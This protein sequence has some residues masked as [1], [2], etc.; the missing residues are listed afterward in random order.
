MPL[1][2]HVTDELEIPDSAFNADDIATLLI[3]GGRYGGAWIMNAGAMVDGKPD[4]DVIG[5][6]ETVE[7]IQGP[8]PDVAVDSA[9]VWVNDA[10]VRQGWKLAAFE[11]LNGLYDAA[12]APFFAA[13]MF[14]VDRA[15]A[16]D[17]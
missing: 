2:Y 13:G 4:G 17:S 8:R 9:Y 1:A 10:C 16:G 7:D 3:Q 5:S 12:S 14:Y 11:N 6:I 15:K